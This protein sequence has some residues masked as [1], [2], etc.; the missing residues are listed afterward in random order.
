[1]RKLPIVISPLVAL[2]DDQ[3]EQAHGMKTLN[4]SA[5][6]L[7]AGV[8]VAKVRSG[9]FNLVFG[10]PESWIC[11]KKWNDLLTSKYFQKNV[12]C[13]VMDEVHKVS[14]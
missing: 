2:M 13:L 3:I 7:Q 5:I 6:R 4:L 8:D 14:W 1:M 12:A 10:S 11:E 9:Q